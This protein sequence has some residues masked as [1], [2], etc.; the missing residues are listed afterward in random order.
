MLFRSDR[1]YVKFSIFCKKNLPEKNS[2]ICINTLTKML[3][4]LELSH[5][6]YSVH[7]W[8]QNLIRCK[9]INSFSNW[10]SEFNYPWQK[11]QTELF[12]QNTPIQYQRKV[13]RAGFL[14]IKMRKKIQYCLKQKIA[15]SS[16]FLVTNPT[17]NDLTCLWPIHVRR[18]HCTPHYP[19]VQHTPEKAQI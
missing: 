1:N 17:Q 4:V 3:K 18:R 7:K 11:I 14:R 15:S 2:K 10:E 5:S 9:H 12:L 19:R 16:P 6:E 8:A 13:D